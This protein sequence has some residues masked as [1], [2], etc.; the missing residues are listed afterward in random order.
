M[1]RTT[2]LGAGALAL[3]ALAAALAVRRAR[4]EPMLVKGGSMRPT[5][6]PGQRIAVAPLVR[7]PARGDLVVLNRPRSTGAPPWGSPDPSGNLE[8]VK[9]VVG[10]PGERVRLLS[11]QLE[12]D[13]RAV[14]EPYLASPPSFGELDLELSPAQYLVLGDH[15]AAST[16]GRDF[17]PVGADA[18]VGRVR[19][20][21]WPPRRLRRG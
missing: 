5:L 8:V 17:G 4:L 2:V 3:G 10:L 9:R 12:V 16:D 6:A 21:Y 11:G 19:F 14:P 1:R 18:L 7:P 15:R 13:G 20:A